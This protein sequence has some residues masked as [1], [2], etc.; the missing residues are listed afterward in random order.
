MDTIAQCPVCRP[1]WQAALAARS[2]V[3]LTKAR[4]VASALEH[5]RSGHQVEEPS[6][7]E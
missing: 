2:E 5:H 4:L 6:D 7:E 3:E 1:L